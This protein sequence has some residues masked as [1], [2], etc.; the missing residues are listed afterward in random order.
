MSSET[1]FYSFVVPTFSLAIP[2]LETPPRIINVAPMDSDERRVAGFAS[3][4]RAAFN[5]DFRIPEEP[6]G[7][8]TLT[9]Q[10]TRESRTESVLV[11]VSP[12]VLEFLVAAN[13]TFD[14]FDAA[15][16]R[17]QKRITF[18]DDVTIRWHSPRE[19]ES[20]YNEATRTRPSRGKT[21]INAA[22]REAT[23]G[24]EDGSDYTVV[25]TMHHAIVSFE[26]DVGGAAA[27][28]LFEQSA[29][30]L[31]HQI[32]EQFRV[33]YMLVPLAWIPA[34]SSKISIGLSH[35][36][37]CPADR[38]Y[39]DV[40]TGPNLLKFAFELMLRHGGNGRPFY[41]SP[42]SVL[43]LR[44]RTRSALVAF[45]SSF[46]ASSPEAASFNEMANRAAPHALMYRISDYVER[47]P[48]PWPAPG[49]PLA[50]GHPNGDIRDVENEGSSGDE[51]D[52]EEEEE[53]GDE[54]ESS[55]SSSDDEDE[56]ED[57]EE[58][59]ESSDGEAKADEEGD[60]EAE[61]AAEDA[62]A[63]M[64]HPTPPSTTG[65]KCPPGVTQHARARRHHL[66]HAD[67]Q[68]PLRD[69]LAERRAVVNADLLARRARFAPRRARR[70]RRGPAPGARGPP[71]ARRRRPAADHRPSK[72]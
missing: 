45:A 47:K 5:R 23:E 13:P 42:P 36:V 28:L 14:A 50:P 53:S 12:R 57:E 15:G 7:A 18:G 20:L 51:H 70:R 21:L 25:D 63:V 55:T 52:E 33:P 16:Y 67:H 27:L 31:Y 40:Y 41:A 64:L 58:E 60:E 69:G 56:E 54:E 48:N 8:C 2:A 29:S 3:P 32:L 43:N 1:N 17:K 30:P 71:Q 37:L 61:A 39:A 62:L 66:P 34:A 19:F 35:A 46:K 49:L 6:V 26:Q 72:P 38:L 24:D 44:L 9:Y 4:F 68:R 10:S 59:E 22:W 65:Y 11:F